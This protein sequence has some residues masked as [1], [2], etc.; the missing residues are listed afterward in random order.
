MKRLTLLLL[1]LMIFPTLAFAE[2]ESEDAPLVASLKILDPSSLSGAEREMNNERAA[3]VHAAWLSKIQAEPRNRLLRKARRHNPFKRHPEKMR[4]WVSGF[5]I[6]VGAEV[7]TCRS[8][9]RTYAFSVVA[10][11]ATAELHTGRLR[12]V[13]NRPFPDE[14]LKLDGS[15]GSI[16]IVL[17]YEA[18][19]LT[20][21]E[22]D[23]AVQ[24]RGLG[25][26]IGGGV[27]GVEATLTRLD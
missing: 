20:N 9:G 1:G 24:G 26:G 19:E 11:G 3:E 27:E 13:A 25:I 22:T 15:R 12:L 23:T 21:G 8:A 14:G 2:T 17:G 5:S 4:C 6:L 10:F 18:Y 7:G 16:H